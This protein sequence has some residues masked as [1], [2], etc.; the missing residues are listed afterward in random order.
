MNK[1]NLSNNN[2]VLKDRCVEF[3]FNVAYSAFRLPVDS[4]HTVRSIAKEVI[5]FE[6]M[7]WLPI[8]RVAGTGGGLPNVKTVDYQTGK[9]LLPTDC[10]DEF[11]RINFYAIPFKGA[12][13]V[14]EWT[15]AVHIRRSEARALAPFHYEYLEVEIG[16]DLVLAGLTFEQFQ[17][18]LMSMAFVREALS[19]FVFQ[20]C[21]WNGPLFYVGGI[22][23]GGKYA[24]QAGSRGN[25]PKKYS[26]FYAGSPSDWGGALMIRNV[27]PVNLLPNKTLTMPYGTE[28]M[29]L[30]T[31]LQMHPGTKVL[32]RYNDHCWRWEPHWEAIEDLRIDLF[33]GGRLWYAPFGQIAWEDN[34]WKRPDLAAPWSFKGELPEGLKKGWTDLWAKGITP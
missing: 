5:D 4:A 28:G 23:Y 11:S 9:R 27:F 21:R 14:S 6:K 8:G 34:P 33:R 3:S 15:S 24:V 30:N 2:N 1:L 16:T 31:F 17:D 12:S 25:V 26:D 20:M 29:D 10:D 18:R 32:E 19:G 22:S 13:E 7:W